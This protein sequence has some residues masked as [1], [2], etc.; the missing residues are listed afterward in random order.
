M[1]KEK[2]VPARE[3]PACKPPIMLSDADLN[4]ETEYAEAALTLLRAEASR[5][6][7]VERDRQQLERERRADRF[8]GGP[9]EEV[10]AA[11]DFFAPLHR[12]GVR[13][14]VACHDEDTDVGTICGEVMCPRCG[15]LEVNREEIAAKKFVVK[16][17]IRLVD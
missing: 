15:L 16:L 14:D 11:I 7:L 10:Q 13:D 6:L 9:S 4:R 3:A 8:F 2:K 17:T 5:R 1:N 12:R